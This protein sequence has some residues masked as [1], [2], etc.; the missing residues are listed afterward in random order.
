MRVADT[1]FSLSSSSKT[2]EV[3][4]L[5]VFNNELNELRIFGH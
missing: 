1:T 5:N 4:K 3:N 2:K